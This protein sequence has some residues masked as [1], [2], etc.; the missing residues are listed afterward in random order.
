MLWA[1]WLALIFFLCL[2]PGDQL[3]SISWAV[4]SIGT[5]AHLSLYF[6]LSFLMLMAFLEKKKSNSE[7]KMNRTNIKLYLLVVLIGI[8]IGVIIEFIQGS[9][10][11]KRHYELWDIF[12]NSIGTVF[13]ASTY[14]LIGRKLV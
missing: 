8:T 10:I 9:Y 11:H 12:S 3:P 4:F 7:K 14:T 2:T 6:G 5:L 1:S 13:G